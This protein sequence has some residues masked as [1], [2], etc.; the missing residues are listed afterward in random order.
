M[1]EP[2]RRSFFSIFGSWH[3]TCARAFW[4]SLD[5]QPALDESEVSFKISSRD[6]SITSF[7][8]L[9]KL[10]GHSLRS[11]MS[12]QELRGCSTK[13]EEP[14]CGSAGLAGKALLSMNPCRALSTEAT[15]PGACA[16]GSESGGEGK[17]RTYLGLQNRP[18]TVLKT[19][20][21]TRHPSLSGK[22][23]VRED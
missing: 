7:L 21:T 20:E 16:T 14:C 9:L 10:R 12:M 22:F 3:R 1:A 8:C 19:A 17:N 18:T 4:L 23:L 5:A 15:R 11:C 6:I 13:Q 2:T